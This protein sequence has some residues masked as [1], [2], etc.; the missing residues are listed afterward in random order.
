MQKKGIKNDKDICPNNY[1]GSAKGMEA[2]EA[3]RIVIRL[4]EDEE[5]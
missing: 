3:A 1:N 2:N 5:V 4:F